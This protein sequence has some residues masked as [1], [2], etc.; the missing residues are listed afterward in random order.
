MTDS[1]FSKAIASELCYERRKLGLTQQEI[2]D[3]TGIHMARLECNGHSMMLMTFCKLCQY[4]KIPY[5]TILN[6]VICSDL[7]MEKSGNTKNKRRRIKQ[8]SITKTTT[9]EEEKYL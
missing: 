1:E 3:A 5:G 2:Y 8:L 7:N 4:L 6:K 9:N